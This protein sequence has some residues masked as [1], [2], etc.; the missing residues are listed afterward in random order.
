MHFLLAMGGEQLHEFSANQQ[1]RFV[2]R[3]G[4]LNAEAAGVDH[5]IGVGGFQDVF[6]FA[7]DHFIKLNEHAL[8]AIGLGVVPE[9]PLAQLD[10]AVINGGKTVVNDVTNARGVFDVEPSGKGQEVGIA[11]VP[12]GDG[13]R[14]TADLLK[15]LRVGGRHDG[16]GVKATVGVDEL[17]AA[18]F[19]VRGHAKGGAVHK[20]KVRV[21]KRVLQSPHGRRGPSFVKLINRSVA[22][23][24]KLGN[25]RNVCHRLVQA[26]PSVAV[27]ANATVGCRFVLL[28]DA[29]P[30][31]PLRYAHH[32]ALGVVAPAV[33]SALEGAVFRP[34]LGELGRAVTAAVAQGRGLTRGI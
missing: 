5:G 27:A 32:H 31:L 12:S 7:G 14:H 21:V 13:V 4:E 28:W 30:L 26:H 3:H 25:G 11:H 23:R 10:M 9:K 1:T 18:G 34:A 24:P 16:L 29:L 19:G 20:A 8:R 15:R 2:T 22:T 33:V 6:V 17:V